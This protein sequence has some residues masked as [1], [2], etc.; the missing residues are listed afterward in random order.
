MGLARRQPLPISPVETPPI[1]SSAMM[2][3]VALLGFTAN[4]SQED[5]HGCAGADNNR[6]PSTWQAHTEL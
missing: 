1:P 2:M 6:I 3:V 4:R 5:A